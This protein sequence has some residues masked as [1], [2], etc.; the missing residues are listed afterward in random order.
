[1]DVASPNGTPLQVDGWDKEEGD[2]ATPS[3][4]RPSSRQPA[5]SGW[6]WLEP[7]TIRPETAGPGV[8]LGL[9]S[10][11]T[12]TRRWKQHNTAASHRADDGR[13]ADIAHHTRA[14]GRG[15]PGAATSR[16]PAAA[17]RA[18]S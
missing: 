10:S 15:R 14:G 9:R 2:P 4:E 3:E 11:G 6:T 7:A 12:T 13:A 18:A 1:M 5:R 16:R 8:S 17:R